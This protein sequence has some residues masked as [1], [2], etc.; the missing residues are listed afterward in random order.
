MFVFL[1]IA[2][3]FGCTVALM[4]SDTYKKSTEIEGEITLDLTSLTDIEYGR[5]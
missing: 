3:L 1:M 4:M 5:R 2:L